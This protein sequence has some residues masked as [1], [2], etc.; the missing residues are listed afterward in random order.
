MF[1]IK[2][3]LKNLVEKNVRTFLQWAIV[4]G[5]RYYEETR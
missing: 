2:N 4:N 5:G 3:E 1:F